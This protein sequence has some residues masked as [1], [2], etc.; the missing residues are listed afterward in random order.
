MGGGR[1]GMVGSRVSG[2]E[3]CLLRGEGTAMGGSGV[4][5]EVTRDGVEVEW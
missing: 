1:G 3:R 5:E 2:E 4:E